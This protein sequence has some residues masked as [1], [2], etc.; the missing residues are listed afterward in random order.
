MEMKLSKKMLKVIDD[1]GAVLRKYRVKHP[2]FVVNDD[3][4]KILMN[5]D[6]SDDADIGFRGFQSRWQMD[7]TGMPEWAM[8]LSGIIGMYNGVAI[9]EE[10]PTKGVEVF[11][12]HKHK[13]SSLKGQSTCPEC[14][15][16]AG[17]RIYGV[18]SQAKPT[19]PEGGIPLA[20]PPKPI[21]SAKEQP[22]ATV[23]VV[24]ADLWKNRSTKM[25]CSSCMWYC[26][27]TIYDKEAKLGRCRRR[28]PTISGY[29]AVFGDDW[30]GDHKLD[31][32]FGVS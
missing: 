10:Q 5:P 13:W 14:F 27:K 20:Q 29:P 30:C 7:H 1:Y 26:A 32:Y 19:N 2:V 9:V 12:C 3:S 25:R 24:H 22:S 21:K 6:D 16:E 15:K 11:Y 4:L 18:L 23:D 28:A 31:E 8:N 17:E